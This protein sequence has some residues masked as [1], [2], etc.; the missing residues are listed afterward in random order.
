MMTE[1]PVVHFPPRYGRTPRL[2]Q[3]PHGRVVQD[4]EELI[5]LPVPGR[6]KEGEAL[7]LAHDAL[8]VAELFDGSRDLRDVQRAIH[9]Q[10]GQHVQIEHIHALAMALFRAGLLTHG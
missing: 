7:L 3:V 1:V 10:T 2:V 4:G 6:E 9:A 5:A 8:I